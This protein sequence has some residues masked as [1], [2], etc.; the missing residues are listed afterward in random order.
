MTNTSTN[1]ETLAKTYSSVE[2]KK[3]DKSRVEITASIAAEIWEKFRN[4]A[5]KEINESVTI[6]GFRK[7]MVPENVLVSKVGEATVNEEMA[8][9]A[10]GKAY[11]RIILENKIDALGRPEIQLTKIAK[12]NPLEFKA[13]VTVMPEVKLPEYKKIAEKTL[14]SASSLADLEVTDKDVD[15]AILKIRKSHAS[16]E[17]HDHEKMTPED[18]EKAIMDSLPEFNDEFVRGLGDFKDIANFKNKVREMVGENKKDELK[19]KNRIR[20]ADAIADETKVEIPDI[21]IETE[22]NRT[23]TQFESDIERMGV[24]LEDYLKHAKKTVEEI[25][26]DWYPHAEKK[27][28]LQLILN[29]ISSAEKILPTK[30]EIEEE[31]NHIVEHYKEADR[32]RATVYAETVLTNEKIFQFLEGTQK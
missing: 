2:I 20:I 23:Q 26:K 7:G 24:N 1:K 12:G 22:L 11:V 25:R 32:E 29:A 18:H 15:E 17:G 27:A 28:K 19:E 9:H 3:L 16:H 30:E 14:S 13:V 8:E 6:D 5:I 21:M 31:V 10:I 4:Q